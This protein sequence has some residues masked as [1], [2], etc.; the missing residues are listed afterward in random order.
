LLS[1][2]S[3]TARYQADFAV[4]FGLLAS[5]G[6]LGLER[7]AQR[8]GHGLATLRIAAVLFV[9]V[10]VIMGVLVSLD[11]HGRALGRANPP[12]WRRLEQ[13]VQTTLSRIGQL[14]GQFEGPRVL[15]VRFEPRPSG[16]KETFWRAM[17]SRAN[18]RI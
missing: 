8:A 1:Y 16:A 5:C 18:E 4:C 9:G 7:A 13:T 11:Y 12:R 17:D 10:T 3:T 6:M 15:K 2:F 14:L